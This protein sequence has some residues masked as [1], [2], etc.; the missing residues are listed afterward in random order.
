MKL[1]NIRLFLLLVIALG[2][3]SACT[4]QCDSLVTYTLYE[5]QFTAVETIRKSVQ[6]APATPLEQP[7]KIYL[8]QNYLLVNEYHKGIHV[9]DNTNPAAPV[10]VRFINIPGNVDMAVRNNILYAD[11]YIDMVVLDISNLADV[12]EIGRLEN[13]FPESVVWGEVF[14]NNRMAI[15]GLHD[16]QPGTIITGWNARQVE[17]RVD[18]NSQQGNGLWGGA[19]R[20]GFGGIFIN[21]FGARSESFVMDS[22]GM[23]G[24][25]TGIG[26]SMARFTISGDKLYTVDWSS[27][28][29]I[30]IATP[31]APS[32]V[33][34]FYI[35]FGIETIFPY[36]QTLF[37]GARTGMYIYQ[38]NESG[39]PSFVSMYAHRNSCDPV[40]VDDNYA[41]VTL[42]SG[43]SCEGFTNQ[44]DVV[45]ISNLSNPQLV[46]THPMQNPH[47]LGI[48]GDKLFI[49]E[50][51][52]G[53]KYFDASDP[54]RINQRMH[55][56][57]KDIH[58]FDVIPFQN[59]LML[60]GNDGLYQF[61]FSSANQ[62]VL[63]S[64]LTINRP[65]N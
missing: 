27:M 58:A 17:E 18:C 41:Y 8:Y 30:N 11:S 48:D 14:M 33:T 44:L 45:D 16:Q 51:Q 47:G 54:R 2:I 39:M 42:R 28:N 34:N 55:L 64:K 65:A 22:G 3:F 61:D 62:L 19:V 31:T 26:G 15:Q 21:F 43:T 12:R 23:Q 35:G 38:L 29:V 6:M 9:I 25:T 20:P 57:K 32:L 5:P 50:G 52:F 7:G 56:H 1:I 49:C 53:L 10:N 59:N 13:L 63:L 60:I 4:D 46:V 37:I 36:K 24:N 40:V